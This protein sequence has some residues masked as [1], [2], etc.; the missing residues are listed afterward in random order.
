[1]KVRKVTRITD[2]ARKENSMTDKYKRYSRKEH[3]DWCR[4]KHVPPVSDIDERY[5]NTKDPSGRPL[6]D[7]Y[8]DQ[9]F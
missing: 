8:Y 5:R 7:E 1:M 3:L 2:I 6:L 9:T 4:Q